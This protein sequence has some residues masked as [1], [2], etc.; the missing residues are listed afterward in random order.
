MKNIFKNKT[1]LITGGTGSIGSELVRQLL[2]FQPKQLRIFSRDESKQYYLM[3]KLNHHTGVRFFIGD[4]RDR[5]RLDF[6]MSGVDF[7]FHA[8]ALKHVP[9]SEYNP[10]EAVNTN[11]VGSQNVI[12]SA[13]HHNVDKVIAISTDKAVNPSNVMGTSKLM[14]EKLII[15]A[16]FYRG[17][18]RTKF[19]CVRFGN[20]AWA[21]GS[22]LLLWKKQVERE[23]AIH[24][25]DPTM[26]RFL[27]T[28]NQAIQL[29]LETA[30]YA[31][32][33]E[34]FVLKMPSTKIRDLAKIYIAKYYPNEHIT[35]KNVGSRPGEKKHEE[36]FNDSVEPKGIF[37]SKTMI[38][39]VPEINIFELKQPV[40]SYPGFKRRA[41]LGEYSSKHSI[42]LTKI[43]AIV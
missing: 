35:I 18:A 37:E 33:G 22:V 2:N 39:I 24:V 20:V 19:S 14:M 1:I 17:N 40:R 32:G 6:A 42:D 30:Q 12:D 10:F 11:I 3:E 43:R 25:T 28:I 26:T 23:K 16:N 38:I 4:I 27:M 7:V 31:R 9:S 15:N 36:L 21:R 29:V 5:N 13:L 8:A 41:A 34:I